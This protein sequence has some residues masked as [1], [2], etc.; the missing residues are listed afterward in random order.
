MRLQQGY[1]IAPTQV[2]QIRWRGIMLQLP[3]VFTTDS[4]LLLTGPLFCL[5]LL[6]FI[7]NFGSLPTSP[8]L[9][10]K[11]QESSPSHHVN[12][13]VYL[14]ERST[15]VSPQAGTYEYL[16]LAVGVAP[17]SHPTALE[18]SSYR[19]SVD[20]LRTPK[21]GLLD[22]PLRHKHRDALPPTMLTKTCIGG[23]FVALQAS[24]MGTRSFRVQGIILA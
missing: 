23:R 14:C 24:K 1:A 5:S 2:L 11:F 12:K 17:V 22:H 15:V 20:P 18:K 9:G 3:V 10:G 19:R 4:L 6:Q 13:Y 21:K 8:L 7:E 16:F